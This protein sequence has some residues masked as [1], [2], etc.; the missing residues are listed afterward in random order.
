M[1]KIL[2][3]YFSSSGVTRGVASKIAEYIGG[4]L[5]QIYLKLNLRLNIQMR[6]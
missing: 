6:I 2:V 3:S 5:F 4:D 1:S